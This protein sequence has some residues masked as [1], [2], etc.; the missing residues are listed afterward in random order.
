MRFYLL[1]M[2]FL[3]FAASGNPAPGHNLLA[4]K[5]VYGRIPKRDEVPS[6]DEVA[7]SFQSGYIHLCYYS[8]HEVRML[9]TVAEAQKNTNGV[10]RFID[11]PDFISKKDLDSFLDIFDN[12]SAV[13]DMNSSRLA[14]TLRMASYLRVAEENDQ[15]PHFLDFLSRVYKHSILGTYGGDILNTKLYKLQ[16]DLARGN[17]IY[18]HLARGLAKMFSIRTEVLDEGE[19]DPFRM[20]VFHT[21]PCEYVKEHKGKV[22]G[23]DTRITKVKITAGAQNKIRNEC[24]IDP[25]DIIVWLFDHMDAKRLDLSEC[26]I[27]EHIIP[28][29]AKLKSLRILHLS[30]CLLPENSLVPIGMSLTLQKGLEELYANN[31]NLGLRDIGALALLASLKILDLTSCG[32]PLGSL[33]LIGDSPTLR[34]TLLELRLSRNQRL[35]I[36]DTRAL[37]SLV[38]LEVL[39]LLDCDLPPASFVYIGGSS[40]LQKILRELNLSG[41]K[42]LSLVDA[43]AIALLA[44]LRVFK[45]NDC[46]LRMGFLVPIGESLA[47]KWILHE[48]DV[49]FN[50]C[51]SFRD[52]KAIAL[53]AALRILRLR[54]CSLQSG[55]LVPI[56]ESSTLKDTLL[57]LDVSWNNFLNPK[58]MDAISLLATLQV[59]RLE[60]CL[61]RPRSLTPI[62]NSLIKPGIL[63]ELYLKGNQNFSASDKKIIVSS[64]R[65]ITVVF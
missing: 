15:R 47:L 54:Y 21:T 44:A 60:Y 3:G 2:V 9:R 29:I 42:R 27:P 34:L 46:S 13:D 57:E 43:E 40:A 50:E 12:D 39:N 53:L 51:I 7:V 56:G 20:L 65:S 11:M 24:L 58:D 35:G 64:S 4:F 63:R 8:A 41:N 22:M 1:H 26:Y 55:S 18:T 36:V 62:Y 14:H 28:R 6:P 38:A 32:L 30:N 33:V 19:D 23:F 25:L 10:G 16:H 45:L 17:P 37:G 52:M 5:S 59:L 49:S 61:L 48:L 31:N